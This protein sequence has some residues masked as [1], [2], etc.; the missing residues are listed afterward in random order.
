MIYIF[1]GVQSICSLPGLCCR[2]CGDACASINCTPIKR[3]CHSCGKGCTQ[4][5]EMPLSTFLVVSIVLSA[6]HIYL[7]VQSLEPACEFSDGATIGHGTWVVIQLAFAVVNIAFAFYFQRQVWNH[8]DAK[9]NE[10]EQIQEQ[11]GGGGLVGG[12]RG[13]VQNLRAGLGGDPKLP[14]EDLVPPPKSHKIKVPPGSVQASFKEVFLQD[15]GVLAY[16]F[17]LIAIMAISYIGRGD[18]EGSG[19]DCRNEGF[20]WMLGMMFFWVAFTYTL[21]WYCCKC[22]AGTV[23]VERDESDEDMA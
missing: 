14:D 9:K 11:G 4:F 15:F 22:C 7:C 17:G 12:L 19:A 13:G 2:A 3:C 10:Y 23:T 8:I 18:M 1:Q 5:M 6:A 16:F 21:L 20:V